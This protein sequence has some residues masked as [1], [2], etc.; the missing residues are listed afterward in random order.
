MAYISL[1]Y[2]LFVAALAAVYYRLPMNRRWTVLLIGSISFYLYVQP[3]LLELAC[4][5]AAIVFCYLG[6]ICLEKEADQSIGRRR[7]LLAVFILLSAMPLLVSRFGDLLTYSILRRERVNWITPVGL[8]FYSMQMIAYL[9][10][11]YRREISPQKNFCKFM[12]FVSFFPQIIQGPISSYG[13]LSPQLYEGHSFNSRETVKGIHLILWGFFL[14]RMIADK[15]AIVVDTVYAGVKVYAGAYFWVAAILYSIQLYADFLACVTLSRGVCK[16]FGIQLMDNFN[17]PYFAESIG[18]FWHRWHISL[19]I[20]LKKYIYIPLGGN[21]KGRLRKYINL[22]ATFLVSGIWHGNGLQYIA[23]GLNHAVFQTAGS[24]TRGVRDKIYDRLGMKQ[25][26][27]WRRTLRSLGVFFW[28][29][30]SW[31][32]FRADGLANGLRILRSMFTVWNPYVLFDDSLFTLGLCWKEFAVLLL[33]IA[34]MVWVSREQQRRGISDWILAQPAVVRY[35]LYYVLI[36]VLWIF[37]TY[38]FGFDAK[39]FIYGGF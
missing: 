15:A 16:L 5:F 13:Q 21:R 6:G 23:W 25:G 36:L 28:V 39:D 33:S 31:V 19:S 24:L 12:L 22:F 26:S 14:K 8:A 2:Y 4:F 7:L 1:G 37:G 32:L 17:H 27:F 10:D 34:L 29:T 35:V 18:D 20:W 11:I 38:G 9:A 3:G 30:L